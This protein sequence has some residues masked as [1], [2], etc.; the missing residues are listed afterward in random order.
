M[1]GNALNTLV[2]L[3]K[4]CVLVPNTDCKVLTR[5]LN[6]N[7][8]SSAGKVENAACPPYFPPRTI[9]KKR[10][11]GFALNVGTTYTVHCRFTQYEHNPMRT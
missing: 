3:R 11:P 4:Q 2:R 8:F 10:H 9:D 1:E 7:L 6:G 5:K